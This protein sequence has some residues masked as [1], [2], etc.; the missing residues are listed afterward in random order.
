LGLPL[1]TTLKELALGTLRILDV[2]QL[3]ANVPIVVLHREG[4][5]LSK[6]AQ[7][8]LDDLLNTTN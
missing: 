2:P 3:D 5:Y 1:K 8:L 4:G 6:A 7:T